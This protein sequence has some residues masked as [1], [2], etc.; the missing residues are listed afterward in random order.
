MPDLNDLLPVGVGGDIG[1][2]AMLRAFHEEYGVR[3]VVLSAVRTKVVQDSAILE[4][5]VEPGLSEPEVLLGALERIAAEHPGRRPVLLVNNDALIRP[6]AEQRDRLEAA[7]YALPLCEPKTLDGPS[8]KAGFARICAELDI[9]TPQ[10]LVVPMDDPAAVAK[11]VDELPFEFPVVVKPSDSAAW[12]GV[13][14][15]GKLK[16]HRVVTPTD[17][18]DLLARVRESGYR[19]ELMV[20]ELIPGDE[21]QLGS[22]TGYRD[23]R[24]EVTLLA[25]GRVLLQE[26]TPGTIGIPAAILTD[27]DTAA[28][29]DAERFLHATDHRGFA[30]FDYKRDPRTGRHVFF[31]MNPR[32]GRNNYYVTA[33]GANIARVAVADTVLDEAIEPLA[34]DDEVLYCVVPLGLLKKYLPSAE[35]TEQVEAVAKDGRMVHP[36]KYA[37]DRGMK[38]RLVVEGQT[39]NQRRKY[40]QFYPEYLPDGF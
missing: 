24:G 23:S 28:R 17:L 22:L 38:R 15:E 21:T 9:A 35:L 12:A 6:L 18:T 36:L 30:N 14:F 26:H 39:Q 16:V 27:V 4:S 11:V 37:G 10:S 5:V 34:A 32:I 2:Y 31:E 29:R 7:G 8:T 20:Q 3:G 1:V 25:G 33:A 40:R 13:S 19:S